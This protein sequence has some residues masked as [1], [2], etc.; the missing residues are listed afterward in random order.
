MSAQVPDAPGWWWGSV[1]AGAPR[2]WEVQRAWTRSPRGAVPLLFVRLE[3]GAWLPLGDLAIT[4]LGPV[5]P[6]G[7]VPAPTHAREIREA[8]EAGHRAGYDA[9]R[10]PGATGRS[11]WAADMW[12]WSDT[13][14]LLQRRYPD[15][16]AAVE[17]GEA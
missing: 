9:A 12:A 3:Q 1:G 6:P 8:W 15:A 16:L 5:A 14:A 10:S 13:R 4:W 17:R 2:C 7:S 11:G